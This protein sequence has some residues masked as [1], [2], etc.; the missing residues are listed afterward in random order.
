MVKANGKPNF[1]EIYLKEFD[2]CFIYGTVK[3]LILRSS[4]VWNRDV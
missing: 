3:Y 4:D 2:L 1:F